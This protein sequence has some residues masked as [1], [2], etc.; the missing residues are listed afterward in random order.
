MGRTATVEM[1]AGQYPDVNF[2]V[3]H[4][5]GF[6]D[7]WMVHLQVVDEFARL[8]NVYADT[9]GV[10]YF[11]AL[12]LAVRRGGPGKLIFGSDGPQP[13][14]GVELHK[15]RQLCLPPRRKPWPPG[16]RSCAC[17]AR[18]SQPRR[19]ARRAGSAVSSGPGHRAKPIG[20]CRNKPGASAGSIL[21]GYD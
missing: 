10:R 21:S 4:L 2:I 1:L 5:G 20:H 16:A 14:P 11:D 7:D 15:V 17:W 8:P 12:V 3:P 9:S 6:A 19:R 18:G 13:H